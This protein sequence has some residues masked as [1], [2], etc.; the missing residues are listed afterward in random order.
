MY[1]PSGLFPHQINKLAFILPCV[2]SATLYVNQYTPFKEECS[3]WD[4]PTT[5]FSMLSSAQSIAFGDIL[6]NLIK[7]LQKFLIQT[8]ILVCCLGWGE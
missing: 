8:L 6:K 4:I 7:L 1:R 3:I 5:L 2:F